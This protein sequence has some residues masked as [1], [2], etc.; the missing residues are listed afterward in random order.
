MPRK[1]SKKKGKLPFAVI[2]KPFIE[3]ITFTVNSLERD[4]N[5]R[6]RHVDSAQELFSQEFRNAIN[7]F[8]TIF[9]ICADTPKTR[10]DCRYSLFHCLR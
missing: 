9:Y 4:R 2:E 1:I 10:T 6:Y 8:H 5:F 7:T 3:L